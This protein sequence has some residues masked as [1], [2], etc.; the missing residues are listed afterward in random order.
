MKEKAKEEVVQND[1][2][3]AIRRGDAT[4]LLRLLD[5]NEKVREAFIS[6]L[7]TITENDQLWK[8]WESVLKS[9]EG[10]A[11]IPPLFRVLA[12]AKRTDVSQGYA[13]KDLNRPIMIAE[14]AM[15]AAA[16]PLFL[17]Y[18]SGFDLPPTAQVVFTAISFF[19][20][21]IAIVSSHEV[22]SDYTSAQERKAK[23][24]RLERRL[25]QIR[26]SIAGSDM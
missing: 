17:K 13:P 8:S 9:E 2:L 4:P 12:D 5:T 19:A 20:S 26:D 7:D 14:H 15:T 25:S 22:Y 23:I 3:D 6:G 21:L 1:V 10:R 18:V 11:F 24:A 16:A